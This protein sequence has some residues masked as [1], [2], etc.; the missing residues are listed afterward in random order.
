MAAKRAR[1]TSTTRVSGNLALSD[2]E[3]ERRLD[4]SGR[5]DFDQAYRRRQASKAELRARQRAKQK[6]AVRPAQHVSPVLVLGIVVVSGL[7]VLL[8][9]CYVRL[10]TISRHIVSMKK[11]LGQLEVEHVNLLT[12]YEQA[13]D[14]ATV[15]E[16]AQAAG[17][18]QPSDSQIYYIDL[19]GADQAVTYAGGGGGPRQWLASLRTSFTSLLGS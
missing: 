18:T 9:L 5:M 14:L 17:M 4:N 13:F 12:R 15:N 7:M 2:R 1:Y 10:N 16:K 11:E 8:L 3:L 6:A 19:P